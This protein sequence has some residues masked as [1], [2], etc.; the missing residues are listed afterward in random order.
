MKPRN[1]R[2]NGLIIPF[3]LRLTEDGSPYH[4]ANLQVGRT[5]RVSR[6]P[7]PAVEQNGQG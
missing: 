1:S 4:L 3:N 7:D 5:L 6:R 2:N